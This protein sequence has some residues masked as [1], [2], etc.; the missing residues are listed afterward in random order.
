MGFGESDQASEHARGE[1]GYSFD[2][3]GGWQNWGESVENVRGREV[4]EAVLVSDSRGEGSEFHVAN[5]R[6]ARRIQGR[7][8]SIG[9]FPVIGAPVGKWDPFLRNLLG[10]FD[11]AW[12]LSMKLGGGKSRTN[13]EAV[14]ANVITSSGISFPYPRVEDHVPTSVRT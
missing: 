3:T 13:I 11:G 7:P 5:V 9:G 12:G 14:D 1:L 8:G 6:F 10:R 4:H 2:S